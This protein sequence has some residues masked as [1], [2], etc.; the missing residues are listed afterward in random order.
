LKAAGARNNGQAVT[1]NEVND[2]D[3]PRRIDFKR[4]FEVLSVKRSLIPAAIGLTGADTML[5]KRAWIKKGTH[6]RLT[7]SLIL[8][9]KRT[10][11]GG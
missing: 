9:S 5:I 3:F 10:A 4:M 6:V 7:T 8:V 11:R 1:L 2:C